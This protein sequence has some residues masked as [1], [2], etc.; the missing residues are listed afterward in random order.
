MEVIRIQHYPLTSTSL[1]LKF[2]VMANCATISIAR[3]YLLLFLQGA[4]QIFHVQIG[5]A[6]RAIGQTLTRLCLVTIL[7]IVAV[8]N[9]QKT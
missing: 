5:V 7:S 3:T 1:S 8:G 6:R 2:R 9:T 4:L